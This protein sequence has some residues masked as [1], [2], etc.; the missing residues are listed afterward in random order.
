MKRSLLFALLL[1]AG[2]TGDAII[3]YPSPAADDDDAVDDDDAAPGP[4]FS[5]PGPT[6]A[7]NTTLVEL[8]RGGKT[9]YIDIWYPSDA[10]GDN[11]EYGEDEFVLEGESIVDGAGACDEPR[12]VMVHSHGNTSIRWEMYWLHEHMAT[13][14]WVIAAPDHPGNTFYDESA[15][16]IDLYAQRPH[17]VADTFDALLVESSRPG[18]PLEGCVDGSAGYV[19]AGYSF[20]GYTAYATAGGLV[21]DDQ[22]TPTYDLSDRRATG[23]VTYFPWTGEALGAGTAEIEVPVLTWGGARDATVGIDYET[24]H[25]PI[26]STPRALGVF[27]DGGH[28]TFTQLY[29]PFITNDGCGGDFVDEDL[30]YPAA[31]T[32]VLGFLTGNLDLLEDIDGALEWEIVA[33]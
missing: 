26:E 5:V 13:H 6:G 14:G 28:Y 10:E 3:G 24:L 32:G 8:N 30:A 33:E 31:R 15:N 4:D 7:G 19:V 11:R 9:L 29:C 25:G 21:N 12:P 18:S 27:P 20:G 17:D 1:L 16:F 2:C 22:G 23:V